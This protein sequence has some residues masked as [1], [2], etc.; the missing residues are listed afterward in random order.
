MAVRSRNGE[1]PWQPCSRLC[2]RGRPMP[3]PAPARRA[4]VVLLPLVV[5]VLLRAYPMHRAY[6]GVELQ[7]MYP[8]NAVAAIARGNWEPVALHHGGALLTV[9]RVLFTGWYTVGSLAGLYADRVDL[10][11]AYASDP[12]PFVL[13][14][15]LLVLACALFS[16][17][18]VVRL[19]VQLGGEHAGV[20][21]G[22][23]LAVTFMHIRESH[24]VWL[25]VPAGAAALAAVAVCLRASRTTGLAAAGVM[26][27][28]GGVALATKLSTFAIALPVLLAVLWGARGRLR[29]ALARL[30][31]AGGTAFV[32]FAVLSPYTLV[33]FR[34]TVN[35]LVRLQGILFGDP[36]MT[37]SLATG[38]RQ[39]IGMGIAALAVLG[40]LAIA[41]SA[42]RCTTAILTTFPLAYLL[43]LAQETVLY[44]RYLA[45][46]APF[47]ALFA[48]AGAAAIAR[49][50]T[51][52]QPFGIVTALVLVAGVPPA[53]Q[54]IAFD[55]FLAL[56]D[57]RQLA[58]DWI[59]AHVPP[60]T[61][62]TVP[63]IV[64]YP[65]PT[66]PPDAGRLRLDYRELSPALQARGL[67]DAK[68]TYPLRYLAFFA[69][70]AGLEARDR[71]VVTA[72]HPTVLRGWYASPEQLAK[73]E[74]AGA[75]VVARFDGFT[76]PISPAVVFEPIEADYVPLSGFDR[77]IRPGPNLT[78]W[79]VPEARP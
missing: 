79:E 41:R 23:F 43:V 21:G 27:A 77:L 59:L 13:T 10:L 25:D 15:R 78:I 48:G 71:F 45:V 76:E 49:A 1:R 26:G 17:Y 63:N 70:P 37:L 66:L 12:F 42:P 74:A 65:N 69:Q 20:A 60:G 5:G 33:K 61:P 46:L 64:P 30:L 7:E 14:G 16:I 57:T 51:P 11:A 36:G 39:G 52:R 31:V 53:L 44:T 68:R 34:D 22:L 9:L 19:G 24:H 29:L 6:L 32:A 35:L 67:A 56:R 75:R 2:Y 73:L 72:D 38:I 58:A 55:R 4:A 54:S 40:L 8:S 3:M 47:T 62:L 50:L 28:A 18:L